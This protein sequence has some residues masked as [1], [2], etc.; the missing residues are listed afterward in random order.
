MAE[1]LS[2]WKCGTPLVSVP[3]PI[4]RRD[5]CPSC[6]ADLHVCRMCDF[7]DPGVSKS[8]REPMAEEVDEKERANFCDYFRAAPGRGAGGATAEAAAARDRLEKLFGA[9]APG[10]P[11]GLA[12]GAEAQKGKAQ[13]RS[14]ASREKLEK[15]FGGK[16]GKDKG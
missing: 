13:E 3:L 16:P 2:C 5:E 10:A 14:A 9:K 4:G 1:R 6:G 8:C 15:M 11:A 12:R 7:H